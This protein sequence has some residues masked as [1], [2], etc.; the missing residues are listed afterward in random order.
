VSASA[1]KRA[2]DFAAAW[3][4]DLPEVIKS[5]SPRD[6]VAAA[7]LPLIQAYDDLAADFGTGQPRGKRSRRKGAN[8]RRE[9][10]EAG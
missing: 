2:A 8:A 1:E 3:A 5:A 7:V 6:L 4:A 9:L 10:R